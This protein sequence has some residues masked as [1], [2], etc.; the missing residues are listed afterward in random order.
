MKLVHLTVR[1][2]NNTE[3]LSELTQ[4]VGGLDLLILSSGT[5]DLNEGLDFNIEHR[6]NL[7]NVNAFTEIVDWAINYFENKKK[8]I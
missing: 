3:K 8:D 5:G 7:L 4:K 2:K 6:T 1:L